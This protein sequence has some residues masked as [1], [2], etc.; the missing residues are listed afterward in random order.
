[1]QGLLEKIKTA[2]EAIWLR[3][4][5]DIARLRTRKGARDQGAS[6][7]L[8]A[9]MKLGQLV[10]FLN[11]LRGVARTGGV[12][13]GTMKVITEPLLDFYGSTYGG[14]YQMTDTAE[15][16]RLAKAALQEVNGLDEY[17][18]LTGELSLYIGRMDY[19]VDLL[20]PWATFGEV[21]EQ[22]RR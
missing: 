14:F 17:V 12:D 19:W 11:H 9:A 20:I 7:V 4:P 15:V 2:R 16:V 22:M 21:Y 1:M 3:E 8:Y 13:L 18:A 10:T 5:A 6:A